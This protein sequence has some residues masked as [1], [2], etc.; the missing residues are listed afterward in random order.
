[1]KNSHKSLAKAV[2]LSSPRPTALVR[3]EVVH[4]SAESQSAARSAVRNGTMHWEIFSSFCT[5]ALNSASYSITK[6][7][8][9]LQTCPD[10]TGTP[11]TSETHVRVISWLKDAPKTEKMPNNISARIWCLRI[12]IR[13]WLCLKGSCYEGSSRSQVFDCCNLIEHLHL[14]YLRI[15]WRV[16]RLCY[17]TAGEKLIENGKVKLKSMFEDEIWKH[18]GS[19]HSLPVCNFLRMHSCG[20]SIIC[21]PGYRSP[22][23]T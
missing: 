1:M 14:E 10:P 11:L 2:R 9:W 3:R 13:M 4:Y 12:N 20:K 18:V 17:I 15:S 5:A 8:K 23:Q 21:R 19:K 16:K 7:A 22:Q 6:S